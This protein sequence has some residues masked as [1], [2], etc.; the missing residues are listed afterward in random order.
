MDLDILNCI[1]GREC[2]GFGFGDVPWRWCCL[3]SWCCACP[4]VCQPTTIRHPCYTRGGLRISVI[5]PQTKLEQ[6]LDKLK[7]TLKMVR[8][9]LKYSA[10]LDNEFLTLTVLLSLGAT[11]KRLKEAGQLWT[12]IGSCVVAIY[13]TYHI[14]SQQRTVISSKKIV[15]TGTIFSH[16]G[17][18]M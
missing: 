1:Q 13:Q 14:S 5:C 4:S 7:E 15:I 16:E 3:Y 17:D 8:D 12:K 11:L 6:K 10:Q 9:S 2:G 18:N